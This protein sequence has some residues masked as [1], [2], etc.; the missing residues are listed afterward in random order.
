MKTVL[1]LLYLNLVICLNMKLKLGAATKINKNQVECDYTLEQI[2]QSKSYLF[3][4]HYV[5]TKDNYILKVFRILPLSKNS[6]IESYD[7]SNIAKSH[8]VFLMHGLIDSADSW[9]A[10]YEERALPFVL[11]KQGYDVVCN[12]I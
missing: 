10:N 3:Q 8:P 12:H 4:T 11:S 1:Y 9:F 7:P 2:I 5:E 6:T